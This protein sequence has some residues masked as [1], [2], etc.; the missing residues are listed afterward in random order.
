MLTFKRTYTLHVFSIW[1]ICFRLSFTHES[2]Q[3]V[4]LWNQLTDEIRPHAA[5]WSWPWREPRRKESMCGTISK[6]EI[7]GVFLGFFANGTF[8][9]C[10][11]GE[12]IRCAFFLL[13]VCGEV[14]LMN[15]P[16]SINLQVSSKNFSRC[17]VCWSCHSCLLTALSSVSGMSLFGFG[18]G[19][20]HG[21]MWGQS[22]NKNH[23]NQR[24]QAQSLNPWINLDL[25][26]FGKIW[27]KPLSFWSLFFT[28]QL[29][30][31]QGRWLSR[32]GRA[33]YEDCLAFFTA[34]TSDGAVTPN[35]SAQSAGIAILEA[36][37]VAMGVFLRQGGSLNVV[38]HSKYHPQFV[39]NRCYLSETKGRFDRWPKGHKIKQAIK[40]TLRVQIGQ[41]TFNQTLWCSFRLTE[42]AVKCH[43]NHPNLW[44]SFSSHTKTQKEHL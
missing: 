35:W 12:T 15:I 34:Q 16:D 10:V 7:L 6:H 41:N 42:L 28:L 23:T 24:R 25:L 8:F 22:L 31:F 14:P 13:C 33:I 40:E 4:I 39:R 19:T 5:S 17:Y 26:G 36:K 32:P 3:V 37:G 44:T 21:V 20:S 30:F 2:S 38:V 43:T 9:C 1:N 29:W 18:F 27:S 11:E